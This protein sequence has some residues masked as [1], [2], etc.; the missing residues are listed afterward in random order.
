MTR[1]Y[2]EIAF[3][4]SVREA[5]TREGSRDFYARGEGGE[6]ADRPDRLTSRET[7]FIA[8]R[9]SFYLASVSQTGWPYLQ[10][11]GGLPGFVR[12]LGPDRL[13][14]PDYPGNRQYVSL[15]NAAAEARV[16]LFFMDYPHRAR[17]K[18]LARMRAVPDLDAE[19]ELAAALAEPTPKLE[20]ERGIVFTVEA[21]DW[22]CPKYIT[23]RFTMDEMAPSIL[24]LKNRIAELEARLA[25]L[26]ERPEG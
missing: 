11:R 3:T 20:V 21:Y 6:S 25:A 16:S 15:G 19:P 8:A 23:P 22:N 1:R 17:L 13:A 9:D 2:R 5:Q 4:D 24:K 7:A 14:I 10:H 26:G 12:V 18:V